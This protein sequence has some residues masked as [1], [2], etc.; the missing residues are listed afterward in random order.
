MRGEFDSIEH[1]VFEYSTARGLFFDDGEAYVIEV[2]EGVSSD[3]L[4]VKLFGK[5]SED[6]VDTVYGQPELNG[7]GVNESL[8]MSSKEAQLPESD[9][10]IEAFARYILQDYDGQGLEYTGPRELEDLNY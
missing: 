1:D 7:A 3:E 9:E 5:G 10:E 8:S 2:Y 6:L 4:G